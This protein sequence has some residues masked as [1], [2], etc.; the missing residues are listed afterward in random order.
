MRDTKRGN[1]WETAA[2]WSRVFTYPWNW[3]M[4]TS[5]YISA[6]TINSLKEGYTKAVDIVPHRQSTFQDIF[7]RNITPTWLNKNAWK[8]SGYQNWK[9]R[10]W[11]GRASCI[12]KTNSNDIRRMDSYTVPAMLSSS[13][14]GCFNVLAIPKSANFGFISESKRMLAG[15]T[16]IW[17]MFC[18]CR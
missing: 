11:S 12:Q 18:S 13:I 17:T 10:Q 2:N 8:I 16:F 3:S 14:T 5:R 4:V 1:S 7:R 9:E 15:F 6:H